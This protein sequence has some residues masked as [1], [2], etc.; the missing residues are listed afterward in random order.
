[1][2]PTFRPLSAW[3]YASTIRANGYV[4]SITGRNAPT[5]TTSS[6]NSVPRIVAFGRSSPKNTRA[7][8]GCGAR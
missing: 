1:M 7:H 6:A 4:R 3:R 8:G 2:L 5:S